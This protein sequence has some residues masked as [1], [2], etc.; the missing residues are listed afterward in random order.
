MTDVAVAG[1]ADR[2]FGIVAADM[3]SAGILIFYILGVF[4]TAWH[5]GYGIF[6]FAVD[7]GL[8]IG[9]KAQRLT[10]AVCALIG[11]GL[12]AAGANSA[13]S[14][15][16]PCGLLPAVLCEPAAE[17]QAAPAQAPVESERF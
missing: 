4:A 10:L 8:V 14:F 17:V 5:L 12:F 1:N 9:N 7:W 15:I 11:F 2:A 13:F 3:Q 6:L 16:R